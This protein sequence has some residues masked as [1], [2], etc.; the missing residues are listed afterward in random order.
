V[1]AGSSNLIYLAFREWLSPTSR[2]LLPDPAYGEY[3]HV[4]Q[5]V[6]RCQVDRL[7]AP[8]DRGLRLDPQHFIDRLLRNRYDL[9]ILVN[10]N[11]PS[12]A[13]LP[14]RDVERIAAALPDHT[15][16]WVDEAY[17]DYVGKA[18]SVETLAA[19]STRLFVC[20]SMSKVYALSGARA[21]YLC[22]NPGDIQAL[23]RLTPP[24]AVSLP[25][26]VAAVA[27]LADPD[28]YLARYAET[29]A[30]RS[31]FA[32]QIRATIPRIEVLEGAANFLL[33]LL[34]P[35]GPDAAQVCAYCR[36]QEVFLRD[37]GNMGSVMGRHALRCAVKDAATNRRVVALLE[38]ILKGRPEPQ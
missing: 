20:K 15:R 12:G 23:R 33:C 35:D 18:Q 38:V 26:Q 25:A 31:D 34:P 4:L 21:A 9:A 24:W 30:L 27:A 37:V 28:Y 36:Q 32:S 7:A 5:N 11:N 17:I 2:V 1:G 13:M 14:R 8:I 16:L 6:V 22:G 19:H 10:P 29:A 3:A